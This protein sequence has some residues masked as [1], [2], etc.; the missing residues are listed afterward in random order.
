MVHNKEIQRIM[1]INGQTRVNSSFL[2]RNK[3]IQIFPGQN[4]FR[5]D[6]FKEKI[7]KINLGLHTGNAKEIHRE[8]F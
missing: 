2:N 3:L 4:M 5:V 8:I 1:I 6:V 7:E